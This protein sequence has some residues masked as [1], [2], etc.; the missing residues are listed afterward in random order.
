MS[1][2]QPPPPPNFG[3]PPPPQ[4]PGGGV[5]PQPPGGGGYGGP[6]QPPGGGGYGGP[7]QPPGGGYGGAPVGGSAPDVG[8]VVS[9]SWAKFQANMSQMIIAALAIFIGA[10]VILGVGFFL[11][12]AVLAGDGLECVDRDSFGYCT[13]YDTG[14]AGF[15]VTMLVMALT[16]GLFF[17]YAQVVG[18]GMIRGMLG[19]TN[20]LPF[21]AGDVFKFQNLGPVIVLSLLIGAGV[22]IGSI[23]C[24]V[25]GLI[26]GFASQ[27]ALYF[28]I[29][30]NL[31]PVDSIKAS[32]NLVKD[33]LG[34]TIIWYLVSLLIILVGELVCLV[35]LLAAIPVVLLGTAYMYKSL[36]GQAVAA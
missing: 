2:N 12:F 7:P 36:T 27:Y 11:V 35:G 14:G 33:N 23:L 19:V 17:V 13:E 28:L 21:K 26:F 10:L 4:P 8:T 20:G 6:P 25:P 18:S 30:K 5:P 24:Y 22:A 3:G 9:W 31:S 16:F 1:G 15:F 32:F 34:P 29:D